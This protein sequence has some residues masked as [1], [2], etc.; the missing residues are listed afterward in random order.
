M[1]IRID[2]SP[3]R[4]LVNTPNW[5]WPVLARHPRCHG[6]R[7]DE[8]R[9]RPHFVNSTEAKYPNTK[10]KVALCS[11]RLEAI[12]RNKQRTSQGGTTDICKS[13]SHLVQKTLREGKPCV[14]RDS[15]SHHVL[16]IQSSN[17]MLTRPQTCFTQS[18][19]LRLLSLLG[20]YRRYRPILK[21]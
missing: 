6:E 17:L 7:Q 11:T 14:F 13:T 12:W 5:M 15:G 18:F 9:W 10:C 4:S 8:H 3:E 16:R 1:L 20:T 2:R 21:T 19:V